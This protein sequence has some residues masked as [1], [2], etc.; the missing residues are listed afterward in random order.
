MKWNINWRVIVVIDCCPLTQS[1]YW[2]HTVLIQ[3]LMEHRGNG[4]PNT[5][6]KSTLASSSQKIMWLLAGDI[7]LVS[8]LI[9]LLCY[10]SFLVCNVV[11]VLKLLQIF[12]LVCKY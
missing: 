2:S 9:G 12:V 10:L 5:A 11:M 6:I 1:Q 8:M 3:L 7:T 4:S